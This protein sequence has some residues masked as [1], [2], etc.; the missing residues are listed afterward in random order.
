MPS[1]VQRNI[2][3]IVNRLISVCFCQTILGIFCIRIYLHYYENMITLCFN[4]YH[5]DIKSYLHVVTDS[6]ILLCDFHSEQAWL[7]WLF[8]SNNIMRENII[9]Y[10]L[11]KIAFS[12]TFEEYC[13]NVSSLKD[14]DIQN[15]AKSKEFRSWIEIRGYQNMRCFEHFRRIM[16]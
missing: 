12:E 3:R 15:D 10:C 7:R 6:R 14:S 1:D 11:S 9:L 4:Y 16:S 2:L 8:S 13:A 5:G